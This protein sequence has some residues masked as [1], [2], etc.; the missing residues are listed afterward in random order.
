MR[1]MSRENLS[2][3]PFAGE[4]DDHVL[5]PEVTKGGLVFGGAHGRGV[6]YEQ[7]SSSAMPT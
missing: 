6:V 4:G 3:E 2:V 1:E 5:F 7:G